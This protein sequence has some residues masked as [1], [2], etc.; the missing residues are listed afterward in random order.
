MLRD[1]A[2]TLVPV[3]RR[4]AA[5]GLVVATVLGP[6]IASGATT[7]SL[8][9]LDI[10]VVA[11]QS[12]ALGY[13]SFVVDPTTHKDVFTDSGRSPADK[14]VLIMWD[15]SG[16]PSSGATPVHLDT[17]QRLKGAP[18]PV[19]GPELGL[20]RELY[21]A[22]H[23]NLLIVKVAFSG[24]S[25]AV[26]WQPKAPDFQALVL[27]VEQAESWA[28]SNGWSPSIGGFYWMQ[29]ES[30]AM[31]SAWA[32]GY[33]ANLKEFMSNVR[34]QLGLTHKTPFVIGEIDLVDF[35][36]FEESHDLCSSPSCSPERRWNDEVISAESS[37]AGRY[38]F[39][40]STKSLPRYENFLHL[41]NKAELSLGSAFGSLSGRHL[42]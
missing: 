29:G 40:T 31:K 15:E 28:Q 34:S 1:R 14:K 27:L 37:L 24:S 23:H 4:L 17:P 9:K 6:T 21:S 35:I 5:I 11:G 41:T 12:N 39:V 20:A 26:D 18:S 22:G 36:N 10:L 33:R 25:L 7:H 19:F 16:V 3:R 32:S 42:T 2:N 8:P 30:D 13:Q 38:V